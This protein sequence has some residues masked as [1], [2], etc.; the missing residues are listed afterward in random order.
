MCRA[1]PPS[2]PRSPSILLVPGLS[3]PHSNCPWHS[4]WFPLL[5]LS[6]MFHK[7]CTIED[8]SKWTECLS[9]S[10]SLLSCL[11]LE[12][13]SC[14]SAYS[15]SRTVA[16]VIQSEPPSCFCDTVRASQLLWCIQSE[17]HSCFSAYS[18]SLTVA[19]LGYWNQ[20]LQ[21]HTGLVT[22][23]NHAMLQPGL[24]YLFLPVLGS[25]PHLHKWKALALAS[26]SHYR[27]TCFMFYIE[28][29][30]MVFQIFPLPSL[31]L[32]S[33]K[34]MFQAMKCLSLDLYEFFKFSVC[35]LYLKQ[36]LEMKLRLTANPWSVSPRLVG[37]GKQTCSLCPPYI[38]LL[39]SLILIY[40][41][42]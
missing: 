41:H 3:P 14:F 8:F 6:P 22:L 13:P 23:K 20:S 1:E 29:I 7:P 9:P 32:S 5:L 34:G 27:S 11:Q 38:K 35:L 17:P 33:P 40:V 21:S 26:L 25:C 18:Q 31:V 39:G 16:S 42:I 37:A 24:K 10:I 19:P 30:F 28:F 36:D 12:P 2:P 15:Q 4:F